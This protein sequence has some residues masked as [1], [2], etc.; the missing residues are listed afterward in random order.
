MTTGLPPIGVTPAALSGTRIT[1]RYQGQTGLDQL[2]DV[3]TVMTET[4]AEFR[5]S[6]LSI[7]LEDIGYEEIRLPA[8]R[9][10]RSEADIQTIS[11][12]LVRIVHVIE[13]TV[14]ITVRG[15]T[16]TATAGQIYAHHM[17]TPYVAECPQPVTCATLI[18][19]TRLL[20]LLPGGLESLS[21]G[22]LDESSLTEVFA[23]MMAG[24]RRASPDDNTPDSEHL[25]RA[26]V[27]IAR[28]LLGA[29]QRATT[30][31]G[32]E[33]RSRRRI[34]DIIEREYADPMLS[35]VLIARRLSVSVRHVHRLFSGE[36]L[37]VSRL[38]RRR[39]VQAAQSELVATADP[40]EVIARRVGF[41]SDDAGYRA[42]RIVV[43]TPPN[44][45]RRRQRV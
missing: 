32:E 41:G 25:S 23:S 27:D 1:F 17:D 14:R 35:A 15:K 10:V 11:R 30:Y 44:E 28:A 3:H 22:V 13:G 21:R 38:I 43:G 45:F 37:S 26:L 4:P 8:H 16:M 12:D 40:F 24:V 7:P 33:E 34:Y 9:T 36:P 20:R 29:Q 6:L 19:P 39:R 5:A 31:F 2:S 18:V 42:F